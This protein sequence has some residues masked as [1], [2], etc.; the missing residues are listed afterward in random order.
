VTVDLND[1]PA[2]VP[3]E[4][5]RDNQRELPASTG[6]IDVKSFLGA[7][8]KLGFDGPVRVEPFNEA[9]RQMQPDQAA[10]AAMS[11]LKKAFAS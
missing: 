1:A 9:V 6:V 3:K 10:D 7:L 5:M 4:Q 11:S 8:E 2:N